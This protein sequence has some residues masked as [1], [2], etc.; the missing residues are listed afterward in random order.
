[1]T[2]M[3]FMLLFTL[4]ALAVSAGAR[5]GA[6]SDGL[7]AAYCRVQAITVG[8]PLKRAGDFLRAEVAEEVRGGWSL[9]NRRAA[10][11]TPP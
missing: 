4:L 6:E 9:R 3:D 8:G 2:P 1:M 10:L 5:E 7:R 11:R